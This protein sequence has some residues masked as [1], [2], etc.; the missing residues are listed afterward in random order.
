MQFELDDY[1]LDGFLA[2][3]S[4]FGADRFGYVVTPNVDHLIRYHDDPKFQEQY[5]NASYVL[6]DSRFL[7]HIFRAA[8]GKRIRVCTGS[9][10]TA[11]LFSQIIEPTDSIVLIGGS[12][13]QARL[14]AQT[15]GLKSLHHYNPPMGFIRDPQE[16]EACLRFAEAH[17]PFRFCFIAV[18]APQQEMFAQLLKRR[19]LARGLALCIG[20]SINFMTGREQRAPLWM[21]RLGLE[22]MYRLALDPRRLARRYLVRGPRVFWLLRQ[23]DVAVRSV[24]DSR[25]TATDPISTVP[26]QQYELTLV[27]GAVPDAATPAGVA[28]VALQTA[29][30]G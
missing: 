28:P 3:A 16:V 18:G 22:W 7:S 8:K 2:V 10:L 9:D 4:T 21:Q 15:Y 11:G 27:R 20:A 29:E 25:R 14:L 5:A 6:L 13:E 17:S 24:V 1:D 30:G 19:R 12:D 23:F 26:I